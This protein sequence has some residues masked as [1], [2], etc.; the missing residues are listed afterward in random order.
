M[1]IRPARV[2][3]V[4]GIYEQILVFAEQKQMIRRSMAELYESIREFHRRRRRREPG[5][6]LCRLARILGRPGRDQGT[7]GRRARSGHGGGPA[8]G[9]SL[10][11]IGPRARDQVGLRADQRGR[12]LR[13]MR[14]S[15]HRQVRAS[16]TDLERMRALSVVSDLPGS[17]AHSLDRARDDAR[18]VCRTWRPPRSDLARASADNATLRH[19]L[20][21]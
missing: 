14:L 6:R 9:R 8:P 5:C 12:I 17:R 10:L 2:G 4:P 16:P 3:D 7:G 18:P 20:A 11:G 15:S 13:A 21:L 1:T 19:R